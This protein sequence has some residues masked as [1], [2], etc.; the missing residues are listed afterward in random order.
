MQEAAD[1]REPQGGLQKVWQ[2]GRE[3]H[4]RGERWRGREKGTG[5]RETER[6]TDKQTKSD[7]DR[8]GKRGRKRNRKTETMTEANK[9]R[10]RKRERCPQTERGDKRCLNKANRSG[11][12]GEGKMCI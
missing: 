6:Q 1:G 8:N 10:G 7:R 4:A 5:G 3:A 2:H 9:Q 11:Q 12:M